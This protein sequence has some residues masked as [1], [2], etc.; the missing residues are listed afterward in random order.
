MAGLKVKKSDQVVVTRGRNRGE[1]GEIIEVMPKIRKVV[2]EGVNVR[3]R[4]TRPRAP[5]QPSG[6]IEFNAPLPVSNVMLV[7]PKCDQATRVGRS[8]LADGSRVRIC[9]RCGEVIDG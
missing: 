5:G 6:I 3:M 4:H 1:R 2:V 8:T 7:C 9:K